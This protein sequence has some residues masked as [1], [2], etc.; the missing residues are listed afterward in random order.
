MKKQL[1]VKTLS[2]A[3]CFIASAPALAGIAGTKH[4]FTATG[5]SPI[6]GVTQ[7]CSTC[8]VPHRPVVNT[9]LW[10]HA[11]SNETYMLYNQNPD[12]KPTASIYNP[13][14]ETFDGTPTRLC[15]SCHD[16]TVAV[17]GNVALSAS[18]QSWMMYN[19]GPVTAPAGSGQVNKGLMGSHPVGVTLGSMHGKGNCM[20]CHNTHSS[21]VWTKTTLKFYKNKTVQ[22]T[23][24]H[25]PHMKVPDTKFLAMSNSGSAMCQTCHGL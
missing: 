20:T 4:D 18:N 22:C 12:Y 19:N 14:P 3:I 17:A 13:S 5:G 24:C 7:L 21:G 9:P 1:H 6:P 25:N 10:G 16:G 15:L 23:T 8:H 11:L 2:L